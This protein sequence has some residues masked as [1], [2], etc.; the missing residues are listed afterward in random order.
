MHVDGTVDPLRDIETI[1]LELIFADLEVLERR[2]SKTGKSARMDKTA[3]KEFAMQ[4]RLKNIWRTG[5]TRFFLNWK[6]KMKRSG[7]PSTI[8]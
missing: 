7:L 4:E 1:D 2:M 6:M 5:R 3:A 8:C